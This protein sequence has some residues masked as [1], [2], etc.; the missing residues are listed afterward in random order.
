MKREMYE[1]A[2]EYFKRASVVQPGEIKWRLMVTSCYRR[3]GDFHKALELYQQIHEDHPD[4]LEA[5]QYLEALC[6]DLG[7]P[8]DDYTKKIEKLRR[9]QPAMPAGATATQAPA[10]AAPSRAAPERS[11]RPERPQRPERSIQR[12]DR[13]AAQASAASSAAEEEKAALSAPRAGSSQPVH[14][15]VQNTRQDDDDDFGDADVTGLLA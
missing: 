4:N 2:I 12:P 10:A 13:S 1:Q 9:L 15:P 5:L 11:S 8:F 3:L 7:R 6:R 14:R